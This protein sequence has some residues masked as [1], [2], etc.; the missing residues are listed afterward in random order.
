MRRGELRREKGPS[1]NPAE[2]HILMTIR[3]LG[4]LS[5]F[6]FILLCPFQTGLFS[7][8]KEKAENNLIEPKLRLPIPRDKSGNGTYSLEDEI[9][10]LI[11][12]VAH[13]LFL[14]DIIICIQV[15]TTTD[16]SDMASSHVLLPDGEEIHGHSE[17][18]V[19]AST[20]LAQTALSKQLKAGDF[21]ET[22]DRH[23]KHILTK[24][25]LSGYFLDIETKSNI[26]PFG[27]EIMASASTPKESRIMVLNSLKKRMII[28]L[29]RIYWLSSDADSIINNRL[30]I[31][32]GTEQGIKKGSIFELFVPE[33][34]W[35]AYAEKESGQPENVG[36]MRVIET[37]TENSTLRLFRQWD[38]LS[39]GSWVV[40][41]FEPSYAL[42]LFY[43][44]PLTNRYFCLGIDYLARPFH[45]LDFGG[46]CQFMRV[47]DSFGDDDYGVGFSGFGIWRWMDKPGLN[48][49][50]RFGANLD[51]PFK[52]DD[53]GSTVFTALFSFNVGILSE[54]TIT[55]RFD[56]VINAGYR[57]AIKSDRWTYS[58]ADESYPAVWEGAAPV[59]DNSGMY[60]SA[61]FHYLLF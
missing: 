6:L 34:D 59:V 36:L 38:N 8:E 22:D 55:R 21:V 19:L 29:K 2:Y 60:Y 7:Q 30:A 26:G 20:S 52:K 61:G 9:A 39:E 43:V 1:T 31:Q 42:E 4:L 10:G 44:P 35:T 45:V 14:D 56:I 18:L 5:L 49:G 28:E 32:W 58:E 50:T 11:S 57:L 27:I 41:H 17:A 40:E 15:D 48:I 46:G 33:R 3:K 53:I 13:Q 47:T 16:V 54:I 23:S 37:T 24:L 12:E 25:N 51:I